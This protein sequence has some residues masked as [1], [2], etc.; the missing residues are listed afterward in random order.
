M[1]AYNQTSVDPYLAQLKAAYPFEYMN[2][3]AR[4]CARQF[5]RA[6]LF[7][8]L[9]YEL[10]GLL[11]Q[12]RE[13]LWQFIMQATLHGIHLTERLPIWKAPSQTRNYKGHRKCQSQG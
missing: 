5:L 7:D 10:V 11:R 4:A 1:D 8:E 6:C 2:R 12:K 3:Y 13:I 9:F